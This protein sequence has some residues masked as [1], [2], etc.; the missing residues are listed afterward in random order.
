MSIIKWKIGLINGPDGPSRQI[1]EQYPWRTGLFITRDGICRRRYFNCA[2][3]KWEWDANPR[4][5][6]MEQESGKMGFFIRDQSFISVERAIALAWRHRAPESSPHVVCDGD[7]ISRNVHWEEEESNSEEEHIEG[8]TWRSIR[9]NIGVVAVD[10]RYFISNYGR[11]R[12]PVGD[13]TSGFWHSNFGTPGGTR[14]AATNAGL[15]N[16]HIVA[17]LIP[18]HVYL[19]R[20]KVNACIAMIDGAQTP[21]QYAARHGIATTTAWCYLNQVAIHA[22]PRKVK[23]AAQRLVAFDCWTVLKQMYLNEDPTFD[24]QLSSLHEELVESLSRSGDFRGLDK[25]AQFHHI[26][27][28]KISIQKNTKR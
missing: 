27:L 23:A 19:P 4:E 22:P 24:S 12:S 21:A 25:D 11:L 26:R 20:C 17:K 13:L 1:V 16:L 6:Y 8:E 15:L 5:C 10:P 2:V 3:G 7:V 9:Y 14:Y 18:G 28:A